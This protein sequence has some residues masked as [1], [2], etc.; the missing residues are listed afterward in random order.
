VADERVTQLSRQ[1]D[2]KAFKKYSLMKPQMKKEALQKI[3][4]KA[5]ER[6]TAFET[7]DVN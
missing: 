4:R 7:E 5:N 6:R 1:G 3:S 2:A